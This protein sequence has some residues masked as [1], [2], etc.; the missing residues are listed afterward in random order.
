[1]T[2][3]NFKTAKLVIG[4]LV[5]LLV[6]MIGLLSGITFAIVDANKDTETKDDGL[7]TARNGKTVVQT[8]SSDF[9]V[10][11]NGDLAPRTKA[12]GARETTTDDD[13]VTVVSSGAD[14]VEDAEPD[15]PVMG[16]ATVEF[17]QDLES[18]DSYFK[19]SED[20][21]DAI[22]SVTIEST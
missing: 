6:I 2:E 17:E 7:L 15:I 16:T 22:R 1:M 13:G 5:V 12:D 4:G 9:I 14:A 18:Y 3:A 10:D 20:E 8:T 19:L 21:I 11:E